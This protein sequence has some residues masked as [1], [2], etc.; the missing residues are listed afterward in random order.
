MKY[1][2]FVKSKLWKTNF[3]EKVAVMERWVF[4]STRG[5]EKV[6]LREVVGI[7]QKNAEKT[8]F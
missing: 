6:A 5:S 1:F 3:S 4:W 8:F 7:L 2:Q